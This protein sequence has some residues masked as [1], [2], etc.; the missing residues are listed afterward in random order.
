MKINKLTSQFI[1]CL[2]MTCSIF[3]MEKTPEKIM[4]ILL[5]S[6]RKHEKESYIS[7]KKSSKVT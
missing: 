1:S 2:I 6:M 3:S 4:S 7:R 5:D